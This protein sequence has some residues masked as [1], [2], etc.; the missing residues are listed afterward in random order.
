MKRLIGT[1]FEIGVATKEGI[2]QSFVRDG[3]RQKIA[4]VIEHWRVADGW[5][6][7]AVV[8]DYFRVET[9][10]GAISEIYH[11]LIG[12]KWCLSKLRS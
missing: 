3:R 4:A 11:D 7:D 8:R 1:T 6:G 9:A 12:D 2:P 5:W 10:K